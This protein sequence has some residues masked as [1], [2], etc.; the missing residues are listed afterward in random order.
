LKKKIATL[1]TVAILSSSFAASASANTYTVQKGDNLSRIASKFNT[2]VTELK[3]L[4]S[5]QSDMIFIKQSLKVTQTKAP[6]QPA[7]V[8]NVT[9]PA[10]TYTIVSGDTL[11]QIARKH[12]ISLGDLMAWNNL[13]GY[14]IYPGQSLKVS[15]S[16]STTT[17]I[18]ETPQTNPSTPTNE[19]GGSSSKTYKIVSGD[20]LGKIALKHDIS[21]GD[22]MSWNNLNSHL[23]FPGQTLKVSNS[24]NVEAPQ[25]V[26]S[27][28]ATG[29]PTDVNNPSEEQGGSSVALLIS[30]AKKLLGTP[31][32]WG[33][34]TPAG[35]DC[36][37]FIHYA[38]NKSGKKV[39]R[40]SAAGYYDRS[41]YV[42]NPVPGDLVFFEGTYKPGIS[43]MG[44]YLGDNQ[45]IHADSDGIRITALSNTYYKQ[46]FESFKRFY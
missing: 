19:Q 38:F 28:P 39:V 14:L 29:Q 3:K 20:T 21:L 13:N 31:Y 24:G 34:T 43:H 42:N 12:G 9:S 45:F 11:G 37:G 4:N 30:E 16:G 8:Q 27:A 15:N 41:Y 1:A 44:I 22:L 33:G 17:P 40:T 36:S 35:F 18:V 7:P 25:T 23:I 26:P 10:K 32:T 46:H 5:L 6:V 2:S